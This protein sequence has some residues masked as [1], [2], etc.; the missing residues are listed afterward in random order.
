MRSRLPE[1]FPPT[2]RMEAKSGSCR[3]IGRAGASA[4]WRRESTNSPTHNLSR[5]GLVDRERRAAAAGR[6]GLRILDCE[7][8]TRNRVDEIDLGACQIPNA[9][10]IHE[11]LHAV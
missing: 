5:F 4:T 11:Q 7:P 8:T 1:R 3:V 2:G 6:G 10:R 9:D